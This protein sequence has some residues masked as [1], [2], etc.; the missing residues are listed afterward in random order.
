MVEMDEV[1]GVQSEIDG[2]VRWLCFLGTRKWR[3]HYIPGG[4]LI[5]GSFV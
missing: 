5:S 1:A 4:V 2:T 3:D